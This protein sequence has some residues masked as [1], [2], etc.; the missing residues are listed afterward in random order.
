M[1]IVA[2]DILSWCDFDAGSGST[3]SDQGSVG[4]DVTLYGTPTWEAGAPT[5]LDGSVSFNGTTQYGHFD[6]DPI[7][8][9]NGKTVVVWAKHADANGG[10]F[11][12]SNRGSSGG[13]YLYLGISGAN[14]DM[15]NK[16][17]G[18]TYSTGS[19]AATT[20]WTMFCMT[21]APSSTKMYQ[22]TVQETLGGTSPT[23]IGTGAGGLAVASRYNS[24]SNRWDG[25][26]AQV[27]LIDKVISSDEMDDLYA[28]GAGVT[29]SDFFGG[30]AAPTDNALSVANF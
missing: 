23:N 28:S 21:H 27:I 26:V 3:V 6:S 9:T 16:N 17:G 5:G 25:S 20:N 18:N 22:D 12:L 1:A 15:K 10:G 30:G 19:V 8:N 24:S 2:G 14:W 7:G 13:S 11:Y 29:Y 4:N